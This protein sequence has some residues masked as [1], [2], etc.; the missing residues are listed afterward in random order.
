M[1]SPVAAINTASAAHTISNRQF[2]VALIQVLLCRFLWAW[3]KAAG[4]CT[5]TGRKG[6]VVRF[7][8]KA[9]RRGF[10]LRLIPS[11]ESRRAGSRGLRKWQKLSSRTLRKLSSWRDAP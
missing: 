5:R 10:T 9:E 7:A 4:N 6:M 1:P 3:P 11:I 8:Y 2:A